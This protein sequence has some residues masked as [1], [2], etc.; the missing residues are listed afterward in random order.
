MDI[1]YIREFMAL[2]ETCSYQEASKKLYITNSA[3]SKHIQKMEAELGHPLFERSTRKVSLT[4]YGK[5]FQQKCTQILSLY[6][7]AISEMNDEAANSS[8][9][10][11]IAFMNSAYLYGIL[12]RILAFKKQYPEV[13]LQLSEIEK[14]PPRSLFLDSQAEF[15]FSG[16]LSWL[17]PDI[18]YY[19]YTEE[20]L[21][22][23]VPENSPYAQKKSIHFSELGDS[24]LIFPCASFL[25]DLLFQACEKEAFTPNVKMYVK[26]AQTACKL[27]ASGYAYSIFPRVHYQ[28]YNGPDPLKI[29]SFSPAVNFQVY[30]LYRKAKSFSHAGK[31]FYDYLM[32]NPL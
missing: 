23:V 1:D 18:E 21:V 22:L 30:C 10:L 7:E 19:P 17:T 12:D 31:L 20:E 25:Q 2:T 6:D 9:T 28:E 14:L 8:N 27:T 15:V 24:P 11:S 26:N 13:N 3:L 5:I 32:A 16:N 4:K 29:I